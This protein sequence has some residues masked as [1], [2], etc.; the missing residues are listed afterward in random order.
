RT[1][2]PNPRVAAAL[3]RIG[4]GLAEVLARHGFPDAESAKDSWKLPSYFVA[5]R[6]MK[7]LVESYW[8]NLSELV[9]L[10]KLIDESSSRERKD[11]LSGKW[12]K[13]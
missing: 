5:G 10:T 1:L 4:A 12:D 13:A 8:R 9:E 7:S 6:F 2:D 11:R 3:A